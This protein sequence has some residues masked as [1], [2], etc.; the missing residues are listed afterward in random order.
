[1]TELTDAELLE[2]AARGERDALGR[3]ARRYVVFV[4]N[5][6]LR[7]VHDDKHLAEDVTQAVFV[8]LSRKVHR[9]KRGTL[10]HGWLFTTCLLYTSPSP[11][12]S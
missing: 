2:A 10:L 1:M 11:R 7:Q 4:Y 8:I 5:A 3:I 12:D 9:L 6:A